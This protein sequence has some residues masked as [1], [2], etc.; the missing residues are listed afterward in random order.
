MKRFALLLLLGSLLGCTGTQAPKAVEAATNPH[1]AQIDEHRFV[2][3][4]NPE[5]VALLVDSE[6]GKVWKYEN[7][8][9]KSVPVP[10]VE[11]ASSK[12]LY[13]DPVTKT[14]GDKKPPTA[15]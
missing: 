5:K 8:E 11:D 6:T 3:H 1:I 13:Y 4:G 9:F 12:M 14:I 15:R 10:G 2:M 7:A